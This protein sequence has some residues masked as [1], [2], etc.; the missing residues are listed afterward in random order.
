MMYKKFTENNNAIFHNII[1]DLVNEYNNKYHSTIKMTPIEGSKKI[2]GK[3]I[4]NIYNFD[5]TIKIGKFKLLYY[6]FILNFHI[7]LYIEFS[8]YNEYKSYLRHDTIV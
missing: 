5:K 3:K 8:Y 6:N 4:Q 1:D 7:K 2:N